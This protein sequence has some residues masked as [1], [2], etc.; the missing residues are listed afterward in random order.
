MEVEFNAGAVGAELMLSLGD[1]GFRKRARLPHRNDAPLPR[2]VANRGQQDGVPKRW[3]FRRRV[4][5][6]YIAPSRQSDPR[7]KSGRDR[8]AGQRS[9]RGVADLALA[10]AQGATQGAATPSETPDAQWIVEAPFLYASIVA[11]TLTITRTLIE[12][13]RTQVKANVAFGLHYSPLPQRPPQ[14]MG[15]SRPLP[16]SSGRRPPQSSIAGVC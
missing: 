7:A 16:R 11:P 9:Q 8:R 3:T 15:L 12:Q 5:G 14:A 1:H 2:H 6:E 4:D 13:N 10:I